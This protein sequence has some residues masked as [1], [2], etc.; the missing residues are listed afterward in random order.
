MYKTVLVKEQL[1]QL[2][3]DGESLLKEL[4]RADFP[5]SAAL[6]YFVPERETWK[7]IVVSPVAHERG[8]LQARVRIEKA[9]SGLSG[10]SLD[11]GDI[12]VMSP[13]SRQFQELRANIE[14]VSQS[15]SS[16]QRVPLSG[17]IFEDA[18]IYRWP[19]A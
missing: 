15:G 18:V 17:V 9:L 7:L 11:M 2:V 12:L 10:S 16:G 8:P 6:W 19:T 3:E 13:R 1:G 14:G 4:D 5:V